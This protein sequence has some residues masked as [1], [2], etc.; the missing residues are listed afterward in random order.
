MFLFEV[1]DRKVPGSTVGAVIPASLS[2]LDVKFL[3]MLNQPRGLAVR[4]VAEFR[5]LPALVFLL[6]SLCKFKTPGYKIPA[7]YRLSNQLHQKLDPTSLRL[8]YP[9]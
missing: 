2:C 7:G 6:S 9:A 5:A 4:K 8:P 1:N 3:T